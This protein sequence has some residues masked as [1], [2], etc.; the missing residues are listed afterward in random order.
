MILLSEFKRSDVVDLVCDE[1]RFQKDFIRWDGFKSEC[2]QQFFIIL[3]SH[4]LKRSLVVKK[5][6]WNRVDMA[7]D[8]EYVMS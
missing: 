1:C 3:A 4:K 5:L 8:S 2:F 6:S 7:A